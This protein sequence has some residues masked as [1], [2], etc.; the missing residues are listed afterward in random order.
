MHELS[1][2]REQ[3]EFQNV[4][5]PELVRI[6]LRPELVHLRLHAFKRQ[7]ESVIGVKRLEARFNRSGSAGFENTEAFGCPRDFFPCGVLRHDSVH[8][9]RDW[10]I[11]G[12]ILL[13]LKRGGGKTGAKNQEMFHLEILIHQ[14]NFLNSIYQKYLHL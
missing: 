4:E 13:R 9:R 14:T 11:G 1:P 6:D 10:R 8:L 3:K 2:A 7:I 12:F 5:V